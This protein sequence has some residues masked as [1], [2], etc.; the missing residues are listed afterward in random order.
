[1]GSFLSTWRHRKGAKLGRLRGLLARVPVGRP[2]VHMVRACR[3]R[4]SV[5]AA[6]VDLTRNSA[7]EP[8]QGDSRKGNRFFECHTPHDTF[9]DNQCTEEFFHSL[10][11]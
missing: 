10:G 7:G 9:A 3:N 4:L 1:M 6:E 2:G 8:Y 11:F 5:Q